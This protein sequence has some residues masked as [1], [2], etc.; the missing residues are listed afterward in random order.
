MNRDYPSGKTHSPKDFPAL[1]ISPFIWFLS[2]PKKPISFWTSDPSKG[3]KIFIVELDY[4][5][6]KK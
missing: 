2:H 5:L 3:N 6:I 1:Q 4:L